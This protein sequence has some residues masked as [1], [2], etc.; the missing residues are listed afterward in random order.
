[1]GGQVSYAPQVHTA[2]DK[3]G[4]FNGNALRFATTDEANTY[5]IDLMLRWTAVKEV[6]VVESEDPVN[7]KIENGELIRL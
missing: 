3:P 1:M 5:L 2:G 6:R 4:S 7:Y